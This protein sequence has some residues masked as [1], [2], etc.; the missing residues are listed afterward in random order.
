MRINCKQGPSEKWMKKEEVTG[1][2][3]G[4]RTEKQIWVLGTAVALV[5]YG[6]LWEHHCPSWHFIDDSG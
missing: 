2:E 6:R 3:R 1:K 4:K 5:S